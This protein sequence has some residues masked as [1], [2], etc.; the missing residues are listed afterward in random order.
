MFLARVVAECEDEMICDFAETYHILNWRGLPIRLSAVLAFGLS[1]DSRT[2][3]KLSGEK[4]GIDTLLRASILDQLQI[5]RW[6]QTEDGQTG[7][8]PPQM[9]VDVLRG[10]NKTSA[11]RVTAFATVEDFEE[12]RRRIIGG[13]NG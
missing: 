13:Q 10:V 8:N 2:K 12:R 7:Q 11:S 1:E 6:Y 5:L 3:R 4:A 9:M